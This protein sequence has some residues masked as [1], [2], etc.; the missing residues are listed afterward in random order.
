MITKSKIIGGNIFFVEFSTQR[1]LC[2]T[3][4][5]LQENYENPYFKDKV[6]TLDE[7]KPW[8]VK[9]MGKW[10]YYKDWSGFNFPSYIPWRFFRGDFDPLSEKELKFIK[11][12]FL[13]AQN[14]LKF[15]VIA[16]YKGTGN[17]FDHELCHALYYV[18][19][20]YRRGMKRILKGQD[21]T[22]VNVALKQLTY[23]P[24]VWLDEAQAFMATG[25][26]ALTCRGAKVPKELVK[27]VK[28]FSEGFRVNLSV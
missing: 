24:S 18:N 19:D 21:L 14:H 8:Y 12:L 20:E 16:T 4:L 1:D 5:R 13:I 22:S 25:M 3:L 15:Y 11:R 26:K 28:T 17:A 27:E 6:F 9:Q 23:H 7:F 2:E 10:S